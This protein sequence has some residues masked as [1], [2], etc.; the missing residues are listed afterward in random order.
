[1]P[2]SVTSL[3]QTPIFEWYVVRRGSNVEYQKGIICLE[4]IGL[5][6]HNMIIILDSIVTIIEGAYMTT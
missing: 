2:N 3:N 5:C 1:M 4:E 6:V